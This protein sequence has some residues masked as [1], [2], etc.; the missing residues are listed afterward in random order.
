MG[1]L[2]A[3]AYNS[4]VGMGL[5]S[6]QASVQQFEL[7]REAIR[8][9]NFAAKALLDGGQI[10]DIDIKSDI[11]QHRLESM[12][13]HIEDQLRRHSNLIANSFRLGVIIGIAEGQVTSSDW[14]HTCVIANRALRDAQQVATENLSFLNVSLFNN[15]LRL[16]SNFLEPR[17]DAHKSILELRKTY[18]D[19]IL[20]ANT[21]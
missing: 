10:S 12:R 16:T 18:S 3:S 14:Q 2:C 11:S 21:E 15:P 6:F 7:A 5:A 8:D 13:G 1:L 9:A 20:R 17:M 19:A 4:G